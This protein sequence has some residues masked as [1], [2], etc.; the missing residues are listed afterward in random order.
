MKTIVY[1]HNEDRLNQMFCCRS[2]AMKDVMKKN[3]LSY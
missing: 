1:S 3:W 2:D